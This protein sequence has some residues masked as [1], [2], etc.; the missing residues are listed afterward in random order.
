MVLQCC[1]QKMPH[2]VCLARTH[3][4]HSLLQNSAVQVSDDR[5]NQI[6]TDRCHAEGVIVSVLVA[7]SIVIE[8]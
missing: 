3:I 7:E 8:S 6:H 4:N 2:L 1:R 5:A